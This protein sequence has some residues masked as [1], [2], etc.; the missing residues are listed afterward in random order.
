MTISYAVDHQRDIIVET[1][2]GSVDAAA[3][4]AHWHVLLADPA[5][6][7]CRRTL[8]DLRDAQ[9]DFSGSE[10]SDLVQTIATP[11]LV[12]KKWVTALLVGDAAQYGKSRQYQAFA[13]MYSTDSIFT[14]RDAA[15][16]WL[17]R[18]DVSA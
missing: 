13:D 3:L 4:G 5:A 11:A 1:W 8:V 18:Q 12:D 17:L 10:L 6:M 7:A 14:E 15:E 16:A 9:M 2:T